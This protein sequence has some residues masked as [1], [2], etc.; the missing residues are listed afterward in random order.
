[1]NEEQKNFLPGEEGENINSNFETSSSADTGGDETAS[2]KVTSSVEYGPPRRETDKRV[3]WNAFRVGVLALTVIVLVFSLFV[4]VKILL[5]NA[6]GGTADKGSSNQSGAPDSLGNTV[7]M[8]QTDE[9]AA[10]TEGD[11]SEAVAKCADTVVEIITTTDRPAQGSV[12][13]GAGS[14]VIIGTDQKGTGTYIVTNNHVI[15]GDSV[16][17]ITVRTTA[18]E[19]FDARVVG[20][21][22]VSDIA[23]LRIEKT[24]LKAAVWASSENLRPGQ[25]IMAIGNPLGMLGGSVSR[26]IISGLERTI[27]VDGVPMKLLQIDAAINPGN[28][29][30]GLFDMNGNLVGIVNAKSVATNVE[31]IGFAI[32][33]DHAKEIAVA[34]A[35][36]GYIAG[37][38]DL[39]FS[40]GTSTVYGTQILESRYTDEIAVGDY[41]YAI[42][43]ADGKTVQ[44]KS[45]DAYR[46]LLVGLKEG[47]VVIVTISHL[48][49]E[50][51]FV[52]A[53]SD[54]VEL[55]VR[56]GK[57]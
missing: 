32:P 36:D 57:K 39:G 16:S 54:E 21:D 9:T 2:P 46:G 18:G 34:L 26:G 23:V 42:T 14:G 49:S 43:T 44:I 12:Q 35:K 29:G 15:E 1:M 28:S 11:F 53:S 52:Q 33:A 30:G 10:V 55:V 5:N 7:I 47:D 6:S 56:V 27:K 4:A 48:R 38:A 40:L 19:E 17:S 50:G 25:S 13:S 8:Q 37:R 22:W 31:G 24:G 51:F 20:T 41:L 45:V 3:M